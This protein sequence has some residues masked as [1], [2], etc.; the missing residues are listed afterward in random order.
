M[1]TPIAK[2]K[3]EKALERLESAI[4]SKISTL[5]AENSRL[6]AEVVKLKADVKKLSEAPVAPTMSL[7]DIVLEEPP[8]LVAKPQN[9][10]DQLSDVHLSLS[11]LKRLVS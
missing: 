1:S 4:E 8:S 5:E 10:N 9:S 3:L 11:K 6:R 7:T 2:E